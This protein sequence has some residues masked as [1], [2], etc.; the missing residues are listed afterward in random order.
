MACPADE[1]FLEFL[2]ESL[3]S[4][5]RQQL[6]SHLDDCPVCRNVV[7]ALARQ[8]QFGEAD[9][10]STT[11]GQTHSGTEPDPHAAARHD[12]QRQ[13]PE[14]TSMIGQTIA[15][16][17]R[18]RQMLG[19][20]GLA[21]V[22]AA[23]HLELRRQVALKILRPTV[24]EAALRRI[25]REAQALALLD[26]EHIVKVFDVDRLRTGETFIVMEALSGKDL[27]SVLQLSGPLQIG[28]A[29]H[30]LVQACRGLA[31]AHDSGIVHRDLKPANLFL[32]S[33]S[34]QPPCVKVLDFGLAKLCSSIG[35]RTLETTLTGEGQ[36]MGTPP[37][38]SPEQWAGASEVDHRTDVWA[39]GVVLFELLTGK[40]PF[41]HKQLA[42][43]AT[44]IMLDAPTS[45]AKLRDGVPEPLRQA[46][47]KCLEKE[48]EERYQSVTEFSSAIAPLASGETA[49]SQL[50]TIETTSAEQTSPALSEPF[51]DVT[52]LPTL[53]TVQTA[54]TTEPEI[55]SASADTIP[56]AIEQVAAESPCPQP[57][58]KPKRGAFFMLGAGVGI[59]AAVAVM[60]LW[61]TSWTGV[62]GTSQESFDAPPVPD[63]SFKPQIVFPAVEFTEQQRVRMKQFSS[64][65]KTLIAAGKY[66]EARKLAQYQ[67]YHLL[68]KTQLRINEAIVR[69]RLAQIASHERFA[70]LDDGGLAGLSRAE[71]N[72]RIHTFVFDSIRE[73]HRVNTIGY[74][75]TSLCSWLEQARVY[76]QAA[77]LSLRGEQPCLVVA[78]EPQIRG[79]KYIKASS[80]AIAMST[81]TELD[82][83]HL[84]AGLF[85]QINKKRDTAT[86]VYYDKCG[87]FGKYQDNSE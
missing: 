35:L 22:F 58:A 29:V 73:Y 60:L 77:M 47:T 87:S 16:K 78:G 8:L 80:Q 53:P 32:T 41:A 6:E 70:K 63:P 27:R 12:E 26:S 85:D 20:G 43:V 59:L 45:L 5:D 72:E 7:V 37:Y 44:A 56:A 11:V 48:P 64:Q 18:L 83:H 66:A 61:P 69:L 82:E 74:K 86:K 54:A 2:Q 1:V 30:Y 31:V 24:E 67:L 34:G 65:S 39:L 40:R 75:A 14:P 81:P 15:G 28:E 46:I 55:L 68:G 25:R 79:I 42:D 38:M 57:E 23:E 9:V 3:S 71:R 33:R 76:A 17:Y 36:A 62:E 49:V 13:E 21:S 51:A 50:S 52:T 10:Y 19:T 4:S 84:C